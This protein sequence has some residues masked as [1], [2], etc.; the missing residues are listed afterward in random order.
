MMVDDRHIEPA[1]DSSG[2]LEESGNML[3]E[4]RHLEPGDNYRDNDDSGR[5]SPL[6]NR[7]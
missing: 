2:T 5:Q 3:V 4:D 7:V 6:P 1:A